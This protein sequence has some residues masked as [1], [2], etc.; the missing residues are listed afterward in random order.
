[1]TDKEDIASA[2][3]NV[4]HAY[5][6]VWAYQRRMLDTINA[7]TAEFPDTRHY[8]WRPN[9]SDCI[10][11]HANSDPV[12]DRWAW[13]SLPLYNFSLLRLP[14]EPR[15]GKDRDLI[16][17]RKGDWM[18]EITHEADSTSLENHSVDGEP[19]ALDFR[20]VREGETSLS[21][22]L[23]RCDREIG[24]TTW[25]DAW[26]NVGMDEPEDDDAPE[27]DQPRSDPQSG[28]TRV[29]AW[30]DLAEIIDAK[31]AGKFANEVREMAP[32]LKLQ[33]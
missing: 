16:Q 12:Q 28:L 17:P 22:F 33:I 18:L 2:L 6:V 13:D 9:M 25:A 11:S 27:W 23:W 30:R 4:R 29:G 20:A 1:M 3:E 24:E 8:W 7:I 10:K 26:D 5:R 32:L 14:R 21:L 31:D 15:I 19:D